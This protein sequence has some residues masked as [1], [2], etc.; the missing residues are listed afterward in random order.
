MGT[1]VTAAKNRRF[2]SSVALLC[3]DLTGHAGVVEEGESD[4][5]GGDSRS[6]RLK[7]FPEN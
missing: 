3:R 7:Y 6:E 5:E 2:N 1:E 4:Q